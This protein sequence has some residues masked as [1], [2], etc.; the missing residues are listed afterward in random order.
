VR[1][2]LSGLSTR[3]RSFL[4]AGL[5]A[6]LCSIL[7]G[8]RDILRIGVLL[9]TLPLVSAAVVARTRYRLACTRTVLPARV[10]AGQESSVVVALENVSRLPSGLMLVEDNVPYA[11]GN[12]PR[13]VL[14]R[15]EPRGRR[16]L[17]YPVRSAIR[18]RFA[19]GP[20]SI[21][22]TDPFGMCELTRSFTSRD[23]LIV[24]PVVEQLPIVH[25]GGEWAGSGESR[26]RSVS[27]AGEDDVATREYRLGDDLRRVHWR[28][29]AKQGELMVRREEQPWQSRCT[30]LLDTRSIG[31]RG[32]GMTSSFEW[33]VSAAA[34]I[35]VHLSRRGYAVRLV[36]DTGATV[37]SASHD[38][39]FGIGQFEGALLDALAVVQPSGV[40][41]MRTA[42]ESLRRGGGDG[43]VVAVLG[44]LPADEAQHLAR[45]R[46]G[47]T[48]GVCVLLDAQ[49]WSRAGAQR[50]RSD[51]TTFAGSLAILRRS[52]WRVLEASA[53]DT[54]AALWPQAD[55][56]LS[57]VDLP[58]TVGRSA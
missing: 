10:P 30:L 21:R 26:A 42:A 43:L 17:T 25:L 19:I 50:R 58:V 41:T 6:A 13:F 55:R 37:A 36:L 29:T 49:T 9:C 48:S 24:T 39:G 35:G 52:G 45:V 1:K 16:E 2:A 38:P 33:A 47:S 12:R 23:L 51:P 20:L 57:T 11:V 28:S 8:Q 44:N 46:H 4:A 34:S 14:D 18:G 54:M 40:T 7:L 5:A 53:G 22:L 15:V 56:S 3:G 31:H 32:E 27:A